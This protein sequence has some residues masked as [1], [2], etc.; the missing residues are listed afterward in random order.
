MSI[1]INYLYYLKLH[2]KVNYNSILLPNKHIINNENVNKSN[3][4][5]ILD[6]KLR[7]FAKNKLKII[8][9]CMLGIKILF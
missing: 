1:I 2:V 7:I 8:F 9:L 3:N 4:I 6:S 5:I